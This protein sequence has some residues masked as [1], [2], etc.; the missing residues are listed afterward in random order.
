MRGVLSR[1]PSL[2]RG[3]LRVEAAPGTRLE[4]VLFDINSFLRQ[5]GIDLLDGVL[6]Q[7]AALPAKLAIL[8]EVLRRHAILLWF[9]DFECISASGGS[10][11]SRCMRFF[12][13]EAAGL[14]G[15]RGKLLLVSDGTGPDG[16]RPE[17]AGLPLLTLDRTTGI[18]R[19]AF[20][21][22]LGQEFPL[23]G[24]ISDELPASR[25][26]PTPLAMRIRHAALAA[27][28]PH[29]REEI[30]ART[31]G[32]GIPALLGEVRKHLPEAALRAIEAAAA[33][34]VPMGRGAL[35]ALVP[36]P[37]G[38]SEEG[39]AEALRRW[40]LLEPSEGDS[41][42]L[43]LHPEVRA[44]VEWNASLAAKDGWRLLLKKAGLHF[45]ETG[46][47]T[48]D[49]CFLLRARNRLFEGGH[50]EEAYEVQKGFL[51]EL[52]RRGLYELT[53][54]L[55]ENAADTT[56]GAPRAVSLGNLAI[57][58]KNE[59]ELDEAVRIYEQVRQE[60]EAVGDLPNVARVF[61]Q[62]GNTH[63]LRGDHERALESYRQSLDISQ[64]I[65]ERTVA[66]AT[67]I[68][69][70]N[71]Q[72]VRGEHGEA[73]DGYRGTL[74]LAEEID[75]RV[76][77]AALRI[78][79]GQILISMK[80]FADAEEEL[81]AARREVEATGDRRS[82]IKVEQL[83]GIAIGERRDS[84]AALAHLEKAVEIAR[85]L[86]DPL[87]MSACYMRIGLLEM[88]RVQFA[89]AMEAY[90]RALDHLDA[91]RKQAQP[92]GDPAEL[93]SY[94]DLVLK[95]IAEVARVVGPE[96]FARITQGLGRPMPFPEI[97]PPPV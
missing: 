90:I 32:G 28:D 66:V 38:E 94:R 42:A 13:R 48:G 40:G 72:F 15:G 55:L 57:I 87:E 24:R 80:R 11:A 76:M 45:L 5:L 19:E 65:D 6:D 79:I 59:G 82:L 26:D 89:G 44:A 78:Q 2:L 25:E 8:M 97:R 18:D 69:I 23:S 33:L 10:D 67:R 27:A 34:R 39:I 73:L 86:G 37:E 75:D 83:L 49:L 84:D 9:D 70:A 51:E 61:H 56:R 52:L 74:R 3:A 96:P 47:R 85:S 29:R 68:Q 60:F 16:I 46:N 14:S 93:D 54:K 22:G 17:E 91:T 30:A 88:A 53:R 1:Q 62:L 12:L 20:L 43:R 4:E 35:R 92:G 58:H 63:Y 7:R 64:E 77:I 31:L 71:V 81:H 50:H 36:L 41:W 95:K 21:T